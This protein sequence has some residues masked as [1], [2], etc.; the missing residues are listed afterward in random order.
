MTEWLLPLLP[1]VWQALGLI[2]V[3][4]VAGVIRGLTGFGAALVIVP[5]LSL[6]L[7]PAHAVATSMVAIAA[8]NIPL[9][10]GAWKEADGRTVAVFY[11]G[12]LAALPF[13]VYLLLVLP[14]EVLEKAIGA[15]VIVASLLLSRPRFR[16][17]RAGLPL[18]LGAGAMA[19]LMNG[20]VG[21][22][23]PPVILLL[24]AL[25]IPAAVQRASLILFFTCLNFTSVALLAWN[26]L[27]DG[28]VLVWGTVLCVPLM[29]AAKWGERLF[30]KAGGAHFRPIAIGV[31]VVTGVA[32]ILG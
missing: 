28:Q 25:P 26:G 10:T 23:G 16:L 7:D 12:C 3:G 14:A 5:G 27:I 4:V 9:L 17:E 29:L 1:N 22:G 32:A 30:R 19:G 6:F 2:L 15:S 31:L 8:T 20:S 13:G 11:L 21:M 24:L 18:K